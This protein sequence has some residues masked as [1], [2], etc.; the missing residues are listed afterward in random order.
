MLPHHYFRSVS[1][2]GKDK[3]LIITFTFY[4]YQT[5]CMQVSIHSW[6]SF[7]LKTAFCGFWGLSGQWEK[8]PIW[9]WFN[10]LCSIFFF[11]TCSY[12]DYYTRIFVKYKRW[13]QW[14][15][16]QSYTVYNK[17]IRPPVTRTGKQI[18]LKYVKSLFKITKICCEGIHNNT[19]STSKKYFKDI[20]FGQTAGVQGISRKKASPK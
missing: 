17:L 10:R 18:F 7:M 11:K 1:Y 6:I 4:L 16:V 20:K 14:I 3:I 5:P 8:K 12:V 13:H 9:L 15:S 2:I 19:F